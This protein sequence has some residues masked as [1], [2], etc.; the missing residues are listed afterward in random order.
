[1]SESFPLR[2]CVPRLD[3]EYLKDILAEYNYVV[4]IDAGGI[5]LGALHPIEEWCDEHFGKLDEHSDISPWQMS[6]DVEPQ[7]LGN[8][9]CELCFHFH[10]E[11]FA[12]AF[13]LRWL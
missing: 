5:N 8:G 10:N 6:I 7:S 9:N 11:L 12:V 13:K 2:S 4:R 1:M 3:G